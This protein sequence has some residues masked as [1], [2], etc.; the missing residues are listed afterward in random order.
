ML[1][2]FEKGFMLNWSNNKT[3]KRS[4]KRQHLSHRI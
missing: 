2:L 4:Q 1:N 3:K